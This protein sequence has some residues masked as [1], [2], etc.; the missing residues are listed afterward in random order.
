MLLTVASKSPYILFNVVATVTQNTFLPAGQNSVPWDVNNS[1]ANGVIINSGS[2][3]YEVQVVPAMGRNQNM[4]SFRN[5][6][7]I[8]R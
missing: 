2:Y 5:I 6:L 8:S 1:I 3:M 4:R 7:I